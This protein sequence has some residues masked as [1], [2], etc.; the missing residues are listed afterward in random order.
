MSASFDMAQGEA[1]LAACE[2]HGA[3]A[4]H[5][6]GQDLDRLVELW[7][8]LRGALNAIERS[9]KAASGDQQLGLAH[10]LLLLRLGRRNTM[11]QTEL[12]QQTRMDSGFLT[13]LLDELDA[14]QLVQRTRSGT[15]RRQ[16][17]LRITEEGCAAVRSMLSTAGAS[18]QLDL[19]HRRDAERLQRL[20]EN[21][22]ARS[23]GIPGQ[24][25]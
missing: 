9:I 17:L 12:R 22:S 21:L 11:P 18:G 7:Q 20:A 13:R 2:G 6:A 25:A 16:V 1:P 8:T 5:R 15:D 23:S 3:D 14:R 4:A 10:W 24:L 19:L